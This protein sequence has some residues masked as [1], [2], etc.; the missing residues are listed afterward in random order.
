M[1]LARKAGLGPGRVTACRA[2]G[3]PV[4]A[5]AMGVFAALLPMLAG[6]YI[7][8]TGGIA[9]GVAGIVAGVAAMALVQ[10]FA[11]PL[12]KPPGY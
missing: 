3:K 4:M 12:V 8:Q 10:T 7:L 1:T 11:V 5:H 2:C 6:F 9:W